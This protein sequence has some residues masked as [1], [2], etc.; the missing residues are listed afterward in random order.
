MNQIKIKNLK[1]IESYCLS[2]DWFTVLNEIDQDLIWHSEGNVFI[3]TNM[4]VQSLWNDED[5]LNLHSIELQEDLT[6]AAFLH[7]IGKASC[8]ELIAGRIRSH[9]HSMK[10]YRMASK[11]LVGIE[12]LNV[13]RR[14]RILNLIRFHG[15]PHYFLS[16]RINPNPEILIAVQSAR[17]C[18]RDLYLLAK[19]DINGRISDEPLSLET[20]ELYK[21]VAEELKCWDKRYEFANPSQ[22]YLAHRGSLGTF[23]YVPHESFNSHVLMLSGLPGAGKNWFIENRYC[24]DGIIITLDDIRK[25]L[26]VKPTDNQGRVIQQT[27]K[28]FKIALAA[29]ENIVLNATNLTS[30]IRQNWLGIAR[31]YNALTCINYI[32]PKLSLIKE[33]N[34]N[35]DNPV[36]ERVWSKMLDRLEIPQPFEANLVVFN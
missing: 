27:K 6:W 22:Y 18:I 23:L 21:G 19:A 5:F 31:D 30:N 32:E 7:D 1:D 13:D 25:E 10:S 34:K 17:C 35:R 36:P 16:D 29:G 20:L 8:S 2:Q 14:N 15:K 4:V 28:I 12:N 3:H 33:Q 11:I 9:G 26:G 24:G